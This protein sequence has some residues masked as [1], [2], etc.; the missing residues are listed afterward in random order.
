M[1]RVTRKIL[2]INLFSGLNIHS[3]SKILDHVTQRIGESLFK[4][5]NHL[6]GTL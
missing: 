3:E 1:I 4:N 2:K 6:M 5:K